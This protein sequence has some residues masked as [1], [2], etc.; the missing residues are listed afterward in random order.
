VL[1][2]ETSRPGVGGRRGD[3]VGSALLCRCDVPIPSGAEDR[4]GVAGRVAL[5]ASGVEGKLTD[6]LCMAAE[7]LVDRFRPIVC[8]AAMCG[9]A[10]LGWLELYAL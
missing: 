6:G 1:L 10:A 4:L 5:L 7:S 3:G 2:T 9:L 8:K